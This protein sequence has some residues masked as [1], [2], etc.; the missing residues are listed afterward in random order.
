[1]DQINTSIDGTSN[2]YLP[3]IRNDPYVLEAQQILQNIPFEASSL[4]NMPSCRHCKAKKF[5]HETNN[6][7][8]AD[9]SISLATN[10]VPEQLYTLFVSN[11]PESIQFRTYVRTYNNKFA[12][13]SFGVKFD[14]NLS[15]RN[16]GIY[17][18][19][20]YFYDAEHEFENRILDSTRMDPSVIAQ[21]MDI[22]RVNPYSRFFR[23]LGDLPSLECQKIC[24]RSDPGLD[25]RVYNAPT[26]SEVA[27][28]WIED[29]TLEQIT[30]RDIF[31]YNHVGG[32]HIVQYYYGCYDPLQYPLL[33][34][35]GDIG[36]HQGIQRI[37]RRSAF[38]SNH[39]HTAQSIDPH[40]SISAE[41]LLRQE[42]QGYT[43][44]INSILLVSGRLLQQFV[45]DMYIKI[46]TS[47]LDYFRNNQQH[48]RSEL[49]Q[50]IVDSINVGETNASRIG[51]RIILP[52]S[53][54]GGPRDMQKRYMEAMTLV[55]RYGKP[56]IFLTITCNP[57]WKEIS[58]ELK[59]H[60]ETQNRPNLIAQVFKA[61]L[62]ELKDQ[63]FKREIFGKVSAYVYVIE[64][65]KRGLPHAHFLIILHRDWKLYAPESFDQIVSAE[66]PDKNKN[67][68]LYTAVTKH[69]MHGPRADDKKVVKIRGHDLDNRWV[70]PYNP[71]LLAMFDCHINVKICST[72]K[73]VKYLY[74]YVYKGHDRVAFNLVSEQTNQQIDEIQQF[75]SARWIAPP[76]AMWRI[77]GFIINEVHPAVYNLH[78]HLENQ[79]QVTFRAH[80]NLTNVINSDLS[81]KSML[82][83]FFSTNQVD[84]NARRLL[85]KEFPEFYV[86]SQQYKMWTVRKKQVVIGRIVTANPSEG[87]RYYLRILLNHI[88]GPLSFDDLKTVN[89]VLA[90]TFREAATMHGLLQRDNSIEECLQEA[91][92]YQTPSNL[93][94]L[95]ATILV[96][97]NPANPRYLWELFEQDMSADFQTTEHS[98]L[99]VRMQVLHSISTTLESMGRDINS[100]QLLDQNIHFDEDEFLSRE[101][102]DELAVSI[103]EEDILA[104]TLLNT[105]QQVVYKLVLEKVFSDQNAAFFIDGPGG[106]GKTFLYKALLAEIRSKDLIAIAT[107]SSGVAASILPGGRTAHSRFK[108]PLD[109]NKNS[110]CSVSKQSGLAKLLQVTKLIIWDEAPM[111]RKEAIEA[112]DRMLKD[113]NDSE[114]PFGGKVVIFGGDFRQILPVIH[115]TEN[116]RA[117]LDPDF[118]NYILELGNGMPPITIDEYVKIPTTMLIPYQ[119][120]STSLDQLLDAIFDDISEYSMNISNMMN[121]AI[122]A[123]KNSYVDEINNLLIQRFPGEMKQYYSFDE[124]IDASEQ[125]VMEDF[126]NT[127]TP[128]G[129]PPHQL[130]LK[131]NCPIML[132]RNINPSEGLC[133]GTRL[134]CRNFD[135]NVIHAEIAIGHQSGKKVFIPRI[136]FLP[137]PDENSGFPFKRTQ[138]PIR[139][140]FAMSINKSQGQTLDLVGIYLPQPV[141]SHGQLY[142]ALSRAKTISAVKILIRPISIEE[143]ENNSTK[144]IVYTE[145]LTIATAT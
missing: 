24:I 4:P 76:E 116:M 145:L 41:E 101:I 134:I 8:C 133:N 61:K 52:S 140:S 138:F 142:V 17:T 111:S 81:A 23:S 83:E 1:M 129:F 9:G 110:I 93:R 7:C 50:S 124:T 5:F 107:A 39:S 42:D 16:R 123:P 131:Q 19:R 51:K 31:V 13:T 85:Y 121:R 77:Y 33:F 103:P 112:L 115:L 80:E 120:D 141:F 96:Y 22:L 18:F 58:A 64:H 88:R 2:D 54:I 26:S 89:G 46:E 100:F 75:Q 130:L 94:R 73:A 99:N 137:R 59:P 139:L 3:H 38:M 60:E 74:K 66:L 11:N 84:Q 91:S 136:P 47:R 34:P 10:A 63:L 65:Q 68:H 125:A 35:F 6:F 90:P 45:V 143:P 135:H 132:L 127:L 71:Y 122:L 12:F 62:E 67:L 104:S 97:C 14:R 98:L 53:F 36:W 44:N 55:Q 48:I 102:D 82:T 126:L 114:L 144:N 95:F 27:A 87:E 72:I 28:I 30:P 56:D 70:V 128:N 15:Q 119:D 105:E 40:Q 69:M 25:Q 92:L 108:M 43:E 37:N 113:V 86:W 106:T 78:L 32:S 20:L 49:Y 21:L 118:S 79:H 109:S 117:R 29:D 57:N